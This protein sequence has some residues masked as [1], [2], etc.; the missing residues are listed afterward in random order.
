MEQWKTSGF[1]YPGVCKKPDHITILGRTNDTINNTESFKN[2][3]NEMQ[4]YKE[5]NTKL[6]IRFHQSCH[7]KR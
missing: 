5:Q 7:Q 6:Q 1:Y 3:K 4:Y 2:Y